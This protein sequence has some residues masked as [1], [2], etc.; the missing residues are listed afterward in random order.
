MARGTVRLRIK[1]GDELA[2]RLEALGDKAGQIIEPAAMAG[3]EVIREAASENAS[4]GTYATGKLARHIVA[5]V[6][7]VERMSATIAVGPDKEGYYAPWVEFGHA[8]VRGKRKEKKVVGRVPPHPF[9]RPALDENRKQAREA[10]ANEIKRRL[11][12]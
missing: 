1:G 7:D 10:V 6:E 5:K 4:K 2:R 3:A 11:G 9:L 8:L 12:L